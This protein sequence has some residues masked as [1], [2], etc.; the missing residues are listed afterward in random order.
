MCNKW[1]IR[2]ALRKLKI[3]EQLRIIVIGMLPIQYRE[4]NV[5][6]STSEF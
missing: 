6:F 5:A 1:I 2:F 4:E 3:I